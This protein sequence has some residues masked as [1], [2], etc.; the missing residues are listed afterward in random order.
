LT[1]FTL[2]SVVQVYDPSL[3]TL[4][5]AFFNRTGQAA[6]AFVWA[7]AGCCAMLLGHARSRRPVWFAGAAL[8]GVVLAKMLLIDRHNLGELPGIF[9]TLGVGALLA[10][11]GYFAPVPPVQQS[12]NAQQ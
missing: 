5:H 10:T 1:T 9:A 11:V 7:L 6:L 2:R 12:P 8:M 3:A 4:G